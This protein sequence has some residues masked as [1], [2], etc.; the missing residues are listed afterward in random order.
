MNRPSAAP[1][2]RVVCQLGVVP[3]R[4]VVQFAPVVG[5]TSSADVVDTGLTA[6]T[7]G[8]VTF[9]V[10][11]AASACV[12]VVAV[13]K[14]PRPPVVLVELPGDTTSR[15]VPSSLIWSR[16][17]AEAPCPMPTVSTTAVIP[18][19]IP[20]IVSAERRRCDRTASMAVQK[21]S[22]HVTGGPHG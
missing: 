14:P 17:V 6:S 1:R 11:A 20:S 22:R 9:E 8:A 4:V 15:F 21:V 2:D 18:M 7:S 13:P 10:R 5:L 16:T 3:V 19:R 12:K